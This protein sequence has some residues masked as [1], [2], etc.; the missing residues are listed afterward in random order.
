MIGLDLMVMMGLL[1]LSLGNQV[2]VFGWI[3]SQLEK[4]QT[5][6]KSKECSGK[7]TVEENSSSK[8]NKTPF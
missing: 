4:V 8:P 1:C 6:L 2:K 7:E 5:L 3:R